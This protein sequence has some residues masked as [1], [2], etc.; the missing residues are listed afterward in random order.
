M[1]GEDGIIN[2]AILAKEETEQASLQEQIGLYISDISMEMLTNPDYPDNGVIQLEDLPL[3][4]QGEQ[5]KLGWVN[6]ENNI[7]T[8]YEFY[9]DNKY[10]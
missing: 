3:E 9:F 10:I 7:V 8:E 1:F 2:R 5:P 6:V 4:F